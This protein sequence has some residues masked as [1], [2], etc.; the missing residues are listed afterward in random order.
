MNS[1]FTIIGVGSPIVD[2][3]AQVPDDFIE[4]IDGEKGGMV[5]VD[6]TTIDRLIHS[7]PKPPVK[8]PGGSAGNTLFTLARLGNHTRFLG[9]TGNCSEGEFYRQQFTRLGGDSSRFK[10]A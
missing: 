5:L 8:A 10:I 4:Q 9:K 1:A 3:I 6:A 2:A 7:L